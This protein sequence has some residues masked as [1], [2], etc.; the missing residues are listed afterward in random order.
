MLIADCAEISEVNERN[1]KLLR[2]LSRDLGS[3]E[4]KA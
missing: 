3:A 4:A 1:D 2:M